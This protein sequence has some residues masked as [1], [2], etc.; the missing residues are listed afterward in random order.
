MS[1]KKKTKILLVIGVC[2]A[3]CLFVG[4]YFALIIFGGNIYSNSNQEKMYKTVATGSSIDDII[5]NL[6]MDLDVRYPMG[7]RIAAKVLDLEHHIYPGLYELQNGMSAFEAVRL[8]RSGK[9]VT[10]RLSIT[11]ARH[12][13]EVLELV[14]EKLEAK[15]GDLISLTNDRQFMDSLGFNKANTICLFLP[16]TYEFYWNTSARQFL[17]KMAKEYNNYWNE[18]R[19][20][21]AKSIGLTPQKVMTLASIVDQETRHNDEKSRIAGV[22]MNRLN[23]TATGGKLQADPTIKF[24]LND[25]EIKRIRKGHIERAKSSPYSTYENPGLPPGP[26]CIPSKAAIEAVLNYERNNFYYFCAQPNYSGY[27]NFASSFEQHRKN[28]VEYQKWLTAE[29]FN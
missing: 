21:K 16:D 18:N 17:E 9:R 29:G 6:D 5:Y 23:G 13:E 19:R 2:V 22:Y 20:N 14:S 1:S 26:I 27:S 28:A 25:F 10:V 7:L 3:A 24:A 4:S 11:N 8:F 12:Y 15:Y